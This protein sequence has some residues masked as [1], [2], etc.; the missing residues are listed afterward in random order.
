MA[1]RLREY[2]R[3]LTQIRGQGF[4]YMTMAKFAET[5]QAGASFG[6]PVCILRIDVDTDPE[7]AARMFAVE[8]EM[9]VHATYYFRLRTI[10]RA[11]IARMIRHGT[12]VGYHF[13]ELSTL[14][15]RQGLRPG[16]N[17]DP[18]REEL[19]QQFRLNV[20]GFRTASGV[21]P[22]TVAAHGDFL[23]RRLRLKNQQFVD[24]GFLDE[25]GIVAEAYEPW[26]VS[27]ISERVAD[28][29]APVW[30]HPGPPMSALKRKP[31][32]LCL[33][34][35]PRQWVRN[36]WENARADLFRG[37]AEIQYRWNRCMRARA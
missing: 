7:G 26:L 11:L 13:E 21:M 30:W 27:R 18:L 8:R 6:G 34:L 10:D 25:F 37:L 4:R 5:I 35:H 19:R 31:S 1:D 22:R 2:G 29:P 20:E 23:N 15:L 36:G 17:I 12:E 14:A 32:V 33:V 28:R 9:G 16:F 3:L 24:H